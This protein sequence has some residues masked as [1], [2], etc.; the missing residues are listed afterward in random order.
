MLIKVIFISCTELQQNTI[1]FKAEGSILLVSLHN[2]YMKKT[3]GEFLF[4]HFCNNRKS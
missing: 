2:I 3:V 1:L 4:M